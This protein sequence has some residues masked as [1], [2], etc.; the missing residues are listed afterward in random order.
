MVDVLILNYNDAQNTIKL[1]RVLETYDC[2][3]KVVIV[4]NRSTDNSLELIKEASLSSK[5]ILLV[6]DKNGGYGYGNNYG[7]D[8]LKHSLNANY[9]LL[10]NP[11]VSIWEEDIKALELFLD[12]HSDYLVAAPFMLDINKTKDYHT[13]YKLP[14]K[15]NYIFSCGLILGKLFNNCYYKRSYLDHGELIDVGTVAGSLF[16]I[17]LSK[18]DDPTVYDEKIFLYCEET[19]LGMLAKKKGLKIALLRE[20]SF[21]H[22]HSTSISKSYNSELKRRKLLIS[23]RLYVLEKYYNSGHLGILISKLLASISYFEVWVYSL[24]AK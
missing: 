12:G 2:I 17:S 16:M 11:D 15:F 6:T 13:A 21:V 5:V 24:L 18:L 22:E 7:F 23:S 20:H 19:I 9:V 8:Y 4:D 1:S 10:C 14:T 3:R